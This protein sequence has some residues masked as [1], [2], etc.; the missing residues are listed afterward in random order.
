MKMIGL[1]VI[2]VGIVSLIAGVISRLT[3]TPLPIAPSGVE[4]SVLL[5]FANSCFLLG[6][7]LLVLK[8]TKCKQE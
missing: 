1:L 4:A 7:A 3:M 5:S 8:A 2:I 6:I